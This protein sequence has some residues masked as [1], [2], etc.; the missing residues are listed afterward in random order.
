[1]EQGDQSQN[2]AATEAV[3]GAEPVPAQAPG[4]SS[5]RRRNGRRKRTRR[6]PKVTTYDSNSIGYDWLPPGW[7]AEVYSTGW[8]RTYKVKCFLCPMHA[9]IFYPP[10]LA[11]WLVVIHTR[12]DEEKC[13]SI[14][15]VDES[16]GINN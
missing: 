13:R 1:M 11:L 2:E 8:G 3:G 15:S 16:T 6:K 9:S 14:C 7:L 12:L 10:K 5:S 4:R